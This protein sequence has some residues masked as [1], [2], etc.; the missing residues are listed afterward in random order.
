[1]TARGCVKEEEMVEYMNSVAPGEGLMCDADAVADVDIDIDVDAVN[2]HVQGMPL[3]CNVDVAD[4]HINSS[5]LS[6]YQHH[7]NDEIQSLGL[8]IKM[9]RGEHGK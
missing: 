3:I 9:G 4:S 5:H 1:M 8:T 6:M 2:E 7:L